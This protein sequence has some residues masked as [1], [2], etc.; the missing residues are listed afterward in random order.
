MPTLPEPS[1]QPASGRG[2]HCENCGAMCSLYR[3]IWGSGRERI[4]CGPCYEIAERQLSLF[5]K[6]EVYT[7]A[8][9]LLR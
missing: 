8:Q 7:P 6:I 3:V 9:E 5:G 2:L 1:I 4:L